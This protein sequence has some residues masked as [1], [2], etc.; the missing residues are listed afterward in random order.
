M[1]RPEPKNELTTG[2][3]QYRIIYYA[4]ND[5]REWLLA[6]GEIFGFCNEHRKCVFFYISPCYNPDEVTRYLIEG[7]QLASAKQS[8]QGAAR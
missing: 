3:F 4:S 1:Q 7:Y 5:A 8:D 2:D 6:E